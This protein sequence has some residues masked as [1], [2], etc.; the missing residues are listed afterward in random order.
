MTL[1]LGWGERRE[2]PPRRTARVAVRSTVG[3]FGHL[4][5]LVNDAGSFQAGFYGEM[6]PEAFRP[7]INTTLFGPVNVTRAAL[8]QLRTQRSGL[9]IPISS[10]AGIASNGEWSTRRLDLLLV[11]SHQ[12]RE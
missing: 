2:N 12:R 11:R 8:P 7:Q 10:T 1:V 3:R 4:D 9:V 6:A 5:V